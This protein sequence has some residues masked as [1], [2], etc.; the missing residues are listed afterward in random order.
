MHEGVEFTEPSATATPADEEVLDAG[1]SGARSRLPRGLGTVAAVAV[2]VAAITLGV[3]HTGGTASTPTTPP[4]RSPTPGPSRLSAYTP[5]QQS[6]AFV[7][8][9]A[10]DRAP[11]GDIVRATVGDGSCRLVPL[12]STPPQLR[13]ERTMRRALPQFTVIDV[14]RI[15]DPNSALCALTLRAKDTAGTVLVLTVLG[16]D[17][18][19]NGDE[20]ST[21]IDDLNAGTVTIAAVETTDD[22]WTVRV[23][24][25]GPL[26][27]E[28]R[29]FDLADLARDPSLRW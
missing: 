10:R 1:R 13:F 28:P 9:Q 23:G 22:G 21:R 15:L 17:G 3:R 8:T 6:V 20:T 26:R 4:T 12:G 27:D 5:E 25:D 16:P 7:Q 14:G 2:V 11:L 24:S 19:R 18:P 29:L